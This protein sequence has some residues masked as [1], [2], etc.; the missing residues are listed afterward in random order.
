[1]I[2]DI[3]QN[4]SKRADELRQLLSNNGTLTFADV[5]PNLKSVII[6]GGGSCALLIPAIKKKLPSH[7]HIVEM[8]YLSSEFR[9]GITLDVLNNREI[10]TL[11]ENFFEFVEINDWGNA[12]PRFLTMDQIKKGKQYY[13]FA[14]TQSGLY[15]YNINDIIEVTGHFN[16]TPTIRFVQKGKGVTNLTGEKLYEDQLVRA[17][18]KVAEIYGVDFDFFIM[19]GDPKRLEYY[20][21]IEHES[22]ELLDLEQHISDL[23]IEFNAKRKSGRLK[24]VKIVFVEDGTGDAYKQHLLRNGQREGQ[25]K[26]VHLQYQN[27]CAFNFHEFERERLDAAA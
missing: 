17:M 1:L 22:F 4:N 15:R 18:L 9:G 2:D 3:K 6:W 24:P 13:I 19:I 14:T 26:L 21:Y 20:L 27:D 12:S 5:W 25:F 7:T 11:H 10:L 16:N 8:G 23:N